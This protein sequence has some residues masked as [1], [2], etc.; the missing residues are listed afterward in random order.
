MKIGDSIAEENSKKYQSRLS[1]EL[2]KAFEELERSLSDATRR[3]SEYVPA[4][5]TS[6]F[7]I[8]D[9]KQCPEESDSYVMGSDPRKELEFEFYT[10]PDF[11]MRDRIYANLEYLH[12]YIYGGDI[13]KQEFLD[14]LRSVAKIDRVIN[15]CD[16][17]LDEEQPDE[18]TPVVTRWAAKNRYARVRSGERVLVNVPI[19]LGDGSYVHL[20][21]LTDDSNKSYLAATFVNRRDMNASAALKTYRDVVCG[22]VELLYA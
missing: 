5:G 1:D 22:I 13:P 8:F 4:I 20:K 19:E 10:L 16:P 12:T 11:I 21:L 9:V 6:D 14:S 15:V 7:I 3:R 17:W 18:L 2:R